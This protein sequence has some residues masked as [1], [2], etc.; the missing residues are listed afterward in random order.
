MTSLPLVF[1][2]VVRSPLSP[3]HPLPGGCVLLLT[4][5]LE[6]RGACP[7]GCG[8][9]CFDFRSRCCSYQTASHATKCR[10]LYVFEHPWHGDFNALVMPR[11]QPS[12]V[13]AAF[14]GLSLQ[15]VSLD[16]LSAPIR[17]PSGA[18]PSLSGP[19][20]APAT[21]GTLSGPIWPHVQRL[22]GPSSPFYS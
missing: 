20:P 2:K 6:H 3:F 9:T 22:S 16:P 11:G 4:V 8:P 19:H 21:M 14:D 10:L 7:Q 12:F 5:C 18:Y 15:L 1:C 13:I 17:P